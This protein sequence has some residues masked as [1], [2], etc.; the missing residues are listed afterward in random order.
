[1]EKRIRLI[2][3]ISL[4]SALLLIFVQGYWLFN[5][6]TYVVNTYSEELAQQILEEAG[7]EYEIRK[8]DQKNSYTYMVNTNSEY[9]GNSSGEIHNRNQMKFSFLRADEEEDSVKF[10]QMS[11]DSIR[12][13]IKQVASAPDSLNNNPMEDH[14]LDSVAPESLRFF[15]NLNFS[16]TEI[17]RNI[18]LA[19]VNHQN[20]FK[21]EL[22]DSII[23]AKFPDLQ[24]TITDWDKNDSLYTSRWEH[25]GSVF[26]PGI[27]I[28]YA[29]SPFQCEGAYI[30]AKL[31]TQPVFERMAVQL[32][33]AL[34]IILLL[35]GCL[36]FQIKTILKQKKVGELR[37]NF[38][39]TMIHE[40][41]R[42]VQTLKTFVAFLGNKELRT[43]EQATEEVIQDSMFELDNLS[44]YLNKL[45]DMVRADNEDTPLSLVRFDLRELADKVIRLTHIPAGKQVTFATRFDMESPLIEADPIHLANVLS[46]LIENAI[47]YSNADVSI[48]IK[49]ACK[50]RELWLTVSDNGIGIP[51]VEQDRVF[52]K[53]YRGSN[54]PD[55]NIPG[56]GLGLSYVK[57]IS[58]AHQGRVSLE[59][60]IGKGTLI[61]LCIPQ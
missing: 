28:S 7:K 24:W 55:Q 58:E 43:D 36:I 54:L 27:R 21:K 22:L 15:A 44:A 35:I 52:A 19:I 38:V 17:F 16:Q 10:G 41:K 53:F 49:A 34:G 59:S 46:N 12:R 31:P 11:I 13:Y 14:A 1:M 39:N 37:Q 23:A 45:K 42:P 33:L 47:K 51:L 20:P 4:V 48:E 56:L 26:K 60:I 32:L 40:L 18:D 2:W 25:S 6:Y 8:G 5:Q 29:Y 9:T 57:L 3:A 61:T 50:G 30:Y